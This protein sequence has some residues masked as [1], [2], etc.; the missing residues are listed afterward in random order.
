MSTAT[1]RLDTDERRIIAITSV[2][3]FVCHFFML[4]FPALVMPISRDLSIPLASVLPISFWMYM[5]YGVLAMGW[6]WISDHWGHKWAMGTGIVVSGAGFL[7]AALTRSLPMLAFSFA[8]VGVGCSAYHPAGMALVSQGIRK[9]GR[10]LG[11]VGIWG[12][13]GIAIVPFAMA[14]LNYTMGWRS[15]LLSIGIAGV[16]IGTVALILPLAV[17]RETDRQ[18]VHKLDNK[19]A[20]TLF[21][22]F[23]VGLM[24][25]GLI[26]RSFTLILPSFL[27]YR[28]GDL[29]TAFRVRVQGRIPAATDSGAFETLA[30]NLVATI[31]YLVGIAGQVIGGRVA[32]RFSLKWSYLVFFLFALPFAVATAMI[33]GG[34]L[35]AAAGLFILFQ[36]GVQPIENSLVAYLTPAKWRSVSF[37]V[38]FTLVFGVGALSIRLMGTIESR[39]GLA[40]VMWPIPV[41][42]TA[43]IG[44]FLVFL[45]LSRGQDIRH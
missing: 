18:V 39:F 38:K 1:L 24:C 37:G 20:T 19:K 11:T 17:E 36:L 9:R 23:C 5:L 16:V 6:G 22:V 10:A 43:M 33:P 13:L 41:F 40:N 35:V 44:V 32:D 26:Y 29:A 15:A 8:L 28:L 42:M 27:E 21:L 2:S 12:N 34:M 4:V 31:I 3:H 7:S 30:A 14:M 25:S 45:L